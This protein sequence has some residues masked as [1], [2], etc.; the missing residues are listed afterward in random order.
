[1]TQEIQVTLTLEADVSLTKQEIINFLK[2]VIN[3][4]TF[5][6]STSNRLLFPKLEVQGLK[7]EWEIY[8]NDKPKTDSGW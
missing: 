5:H 2:D 7:E 4:H 8:G 3:T 6:S 1:M